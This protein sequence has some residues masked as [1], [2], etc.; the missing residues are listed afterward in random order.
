MDSNGYVAIDLDGRM[1]SSDPTSAFFDARI[2]GATRDTILGITFNGGD[3]KDTLILGDFEAVGGLKVDADSADMLINGN[4]NASKI[5]VEADNITSQGAVSGQSV[6]FNSENALNLLAGAKITALDGNKGGTI[7]LLGKEVSLTGASID[8]SGINGGGTILIGGDYQ[9][10]GSVPNARNTFVDASTV[11]NV[12]ALQKG[13]GGRAIVWADDTTR[14]SG[15]INARGGSVFGNG[16]FAEV[17]GKKKLDFN[18]LVD[19]DALNGKAGTLL[20]DP[21]H[22]LISNDPDYDSNETSRINVSTLEN[23][24]GEVIL[25]ATGD[26]FVDEDVSL[27]FVPGSSISFRAD[28]DGDQ[29]GGVSMP[30]NTTIR[31]PGRDITISGEYIQTGTIDT[32]IDSGNG[33]NITLLSGESHS[34]S[35]NTGIRVQGKLFSGS[36]NGNGGDITLTALSGDIFAYQ[37]YLN[38]FR[39]ENINATGING[40]GG[41]I[42]IKAPKYIYLGKIDAG[43]D[44][45]G[46]NIS[47]V[48]PNPV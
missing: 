8:A 35:A 3:G 46:G 14:F 34:F 39:K 37:Y 6:I 47:V 33:G 20:L 15:K 17:S 19:T 36:G 11:I 30:S 5:D 23:Q 26:I 4:L 29:S 10:K 13:N 43:G 28:S 12:D 42:S 7:H 9:G 2:G 25:E 31:A 44:S 18:G 21:S 27:N 1:I 45:G 24:S 40:N 48:I 41:N 22:I 38:S 32:S 16:G